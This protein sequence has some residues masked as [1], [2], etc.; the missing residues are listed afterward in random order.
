[1]KVDFV[2][3]S[4]MENKRAH[5]C[6]MEIYSKSNDIFYVTSALKITGYSHP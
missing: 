3:L 2:V 5:I 6:D 1:M 4:R